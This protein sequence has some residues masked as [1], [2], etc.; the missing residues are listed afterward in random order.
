MSIYHC[1]G[2]SQTESGSTV[3]R[4]ATERPRLIVDFHAH[5][6]VPEAAALAKPHFHPSLDPIARFTT[7]QSAKINHDNAEALRPRLTTA[8]AKLA[9]MDRIGV[10]VQLLS[11]APPQYYYWADP[12]LGRET[13]RL[14]NDRIAETVAGTPERFA[15]LA[16]LPMQAP[17][18]ALAEMRRAVKDLGLKGIEISSNVAGVELSDPRFA[19]IFAAAEELGII[20]FLHPLGFSHGERLTQHY[21]NNV[22]GNPLE[23]AVALSHLIFGGVLDRHPGLKLCV[24]H[25][26]GFLPTYSGRMDHAFHNRADCRGCQHPPSS[27]LKRIYFDTVVFD[28]EHLSWLVGKFGADRI[29]MGSDYP[30]DMGDPDPVGFVLKTP[31]LTQAERSA[32]LGDTAV[33]LLGLGSPPGNGTV[34]APAI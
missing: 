32:I 33:E 11:P 25:G 20:V 16:T 5:M 28:P 27:Y 21:L 9:D 3:L 1:D 31:G 18:F 14:I 12:E 2:R 19:S 6:S 29:L 13:S 17:E 4:D 24:A 15:G 7:P 30:F 34:T 10:D 22:L 8:E 23:A 26:G